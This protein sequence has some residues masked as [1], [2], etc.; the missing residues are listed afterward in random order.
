MEID[1]ESFDISKGFLKRKVSDSGMSNSQYL[2]LLELIFSYLK[3]GF[4]WKRSGKKEKR[5]IVLNSFSKN[6]KETIDDVYMDFVKVLKSSYVCVSPKK[7]RGFFCGGSSKI[8]K[9]VYLVKFELDESSEIIVKKT[10]PN[11]KNFEI[12]QNVSF[13]DFE[14]RRTLSEELKTHKGFLDQENSSW[15][16]CFHEKTSPTLEDKKNQSKIFCGNE[17]AAKY[18]QSVLVMIFKMN[19]VNPTE[20]KR[21]RLLLLSKYRE[22]LGKSALKLSEKFAEYQ[23]DQSLFLFSK[24]ITKD[25]KLSIKLEESKENLESLG[26]SIEIRE[27]H[28]DHHQND[29]SIGP[30]SFLRIPTKITRLS[31]QNSREYLSLDSSARSV[32]FLPAENPIRPAP[33]FLHKLER[34]PCHSADSDDSVDDEM[35]QTVK[36][37]DSP[38]LKVPKQ[39]FTTLRTSSQERKESTMQSPLFFSAASSIKKCPT[40]NQNTNKAEKPPLP[41]RFSLCSFKA[42]Q[43]IVNPKLDTTQKSFDFDSCK[44]PA[45]SRIGQSPGIKKSEPKMAKKSSSSIVKDNSNS[46]RL[47]NN[48]HS[49]NQMNFGEDEIKLIEQGLVGLNQEVKS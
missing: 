34:T 33:G 1:E 42:L 6:Y 37:A 48:S 20:R 15:V 39:Q 28:Q 22:M 8:T 13:I 31:A 43:D 2:Q 12:I 14:L 10:I 5:G 32:S 46:Q 9:N 17:K 38:E 19:L 18:L 11:Q 45:E 25:Q 23:Q 44:S 27:E 41:P 26:K 36:E 3:S 30:G 40:G 7:Q 21:K 49:P 4:E 24:E 29:N 16:L 47:K 35:G